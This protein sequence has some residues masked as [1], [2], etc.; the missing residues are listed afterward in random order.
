MRFMPEDYRGTHTAPTSE[1]APAHDLTVNGVYPAD[2][3]TRPDWYEQDVGLDEMRKIQRLKGNPNA[4][5]TIYRAVP[6][7]VAEEAKKTGSPAKYVFRSGDWVTTSQKYA[8]DHGDSALNGKYRIFSKRVKAKD[9]YT[10]G[11]SIFEWGY[12]PATEEEKT[13]KS[14]TKGNASAIAN[15]AKL[16]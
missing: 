11:D 8:K 4:S 6:F 14:K 3:Y 7:D 13:K 1:S 12:N 2:V 10:N 16:K 9:I 5:I 15:A